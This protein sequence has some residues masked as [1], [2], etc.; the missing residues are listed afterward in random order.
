MTQLDFSHSKMKMLEESESSA[1]QQLNGLQEGIKER[2]RNLNRM[3]EQVKH[4][5]AFAGES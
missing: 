2:D 4:Y 1:K 3:R 5:H